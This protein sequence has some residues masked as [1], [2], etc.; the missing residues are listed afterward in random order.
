MKAAEANLVTVVKSLQ[1]QLKN[2]DSEGRTALM[3][4]CKSGSTGVI[5]FLMDELKMQDAKGRTAVMHAAE[6]N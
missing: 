1:N 4:A 2:V 6:C 5:E 3:Y